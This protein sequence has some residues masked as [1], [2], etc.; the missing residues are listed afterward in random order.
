MAEVSVF[1][2]VI[3]NLATLVLSLGATVFT[4]GRSFGEVRRDIAD[5]RKDLGKIEGMFVLRLRDDHNGKDLLMSLT[6][7][8]QPDWQTLVTPNLQCKA[9][10]IQ[11]PGFLGPIFR[12]GSPFRV[13]GFWLEVFVATTS[14]FS[15]GFTGWGAKLIDGSGQILVKLTCG[16][17]VPSYAQTK[18]MSLQING[19]VP[20][21]GG[22]GYEVDLS[23]DPSIGNVNG[24]ASG[25]IFYS[26]P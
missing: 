18:N 16:V 14:T 20:I 2:V 5:I 15:A 24:R 3:S 17:I 4:V 7:G 11:S 8:D 22:S 25:G 19:F 13:W 1:V 21:I 12:S 23:T 9:V 6:S 10:D 26:V